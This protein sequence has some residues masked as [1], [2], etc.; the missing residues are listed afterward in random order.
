MSRIGKKPILIPEN[1]E[2]KTDNSGKFS[3]V[4]VKGPK[5]ELSLEILP[6]VKVEIKEG[7]IFVLPN[8]ETKRT[9]AIWGLTR[10]L[11]FN[12]T[13]GVV[14]GYEKKLE[15]EGVGYGAAVKGND[16]EL[17]VGYINTLS[18]VAPA[19]IKFSVEKNVITVSGIDKELVGQVAAKVRKAKP[20]EP[21]KGKGI[22][23]FGE[24]IRRKVGKRVVATAGA[25]GA[26]K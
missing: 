9:N 6:E 22:K 25:G 1:V 19:G 16:L 3:K 13:E 7:K 4:C 11:I 23:Y 26:A 12:M 17:K 5:G 18:I 24:V 10:A 20:A 2:V 14:K 8:M 15:I 21:Y